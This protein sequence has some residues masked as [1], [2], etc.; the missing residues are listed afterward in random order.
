MDIFVSELKHNEFIT[1]LIT[2]KFNDRTTF[3]SLTFVNAVNKIPFT[4]CY[5]FV[6]INKKI[7]VHERWSLITE[8]SSHRDIE[9]NIKCDDDSTMYVTP[10]N[11]FDKRPMQE[12]LISLSALHNHFPSNNLMLNTSHSVVCCFEFIIFNEKIFCWISFFRAFIQKSLNTI[13]YIA[14]KCLKKNVRSYGMD[15]FVN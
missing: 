11:L 8:K 10:Y 2:Y 6:R 1:I 7:Y 14:N 15:L 3:L 9:I 13:L 4:L 12:Y 5:V